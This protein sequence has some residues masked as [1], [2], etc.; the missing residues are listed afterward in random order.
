MAKV[1]WSIAVE[2]GMMENGTMMSDRDLGNST[3]EM[4]TIT[5]ECGNYINYLCLLH[6]WNIRKEQG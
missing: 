4:E 2:T 3:I 5:R 1:L 6:E